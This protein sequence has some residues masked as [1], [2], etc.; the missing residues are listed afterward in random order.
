MKIDALRYLPEFDDPLG[1]RMYY[2]LGFRPSLNYLLR[3]IS[4]ALNDHVRQLR[5]VE[6]ECKILSSKFQYPTMSSLDIARYI[7]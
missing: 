5:L 4:T 2:S 3:W 1:V 7:F 6:V